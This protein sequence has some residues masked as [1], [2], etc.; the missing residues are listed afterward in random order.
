MYLIRPTQ[1]VDAPFGRNVPEAQKLG[2]I[3]LPRGCTEA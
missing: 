3:S 2:H 1:L